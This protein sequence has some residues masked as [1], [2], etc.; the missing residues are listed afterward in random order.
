MKNDE[1]V[2]IYVGKAKNLKSRVKQYFLSHTD[3][4]AMIPLLIEASQIMD[5]LYWLQAV[6]DKDSFLAT[7]DDPRER[8]FAEI[9]YGPWDR[10]NGDQPWLEGIPSK[11]PGANLYPP[12]LTKEECW[13]VTEFLQ[14]KG[15]S[16]AGPPTRWDRIGLEDL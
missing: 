4:R 9:N 13:K 3:T 14:E 8:R 5:G 1:G 11:P 12:D 15:Y 6:G 2:V 7:I 16:K 10:L